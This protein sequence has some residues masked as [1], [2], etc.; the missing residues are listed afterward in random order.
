MYLSADALEIMAETLGHS[1][2]I[3]PETDPVWFLNGNKFTGLEIGTRMSTTQL[4]ASTSLT[5]EYRG[6]IE[7]LVS[8]RNGNHLKL[9]IRRT[10]CL[11]SGCYLREVTKKKYVRAE[12]IVQVVFLDIWWLFVLAS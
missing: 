8:L 3:R 10:M 5:D 9:N 12:L 2:A 7:S 1:T 4:N 11:N 6:L